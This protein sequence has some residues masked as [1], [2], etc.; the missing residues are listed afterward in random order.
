LR[1]KYRLEREKRLRPD[2]QR[3]YFRPSGEV[4]ASYA[5][6]P[7]Q[8]IAAREPISEE[9][10]VIVLGA[11]LARDGLHTERRIALAEQGA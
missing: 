11:E 5:A 8:P 6:D 10:D 1:E 3:Q 2:G 7:H 4:V 9:I